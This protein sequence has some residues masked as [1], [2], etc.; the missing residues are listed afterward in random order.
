MYLN[1]VY[2]MKR[3]DHYAM[4]ILLLFKKL[5]QRLPFLR[6][7]R[8][9]IFFLNSTSPFLL[10]NKKKKKKDFH[11]Y[12]VIPSIVNARIGSAMWIP[13]SPIKRPTIIVN[14]FP[15]QSVKRW[16]AIGCNDQECF[17]FWSCIWVLEELLC[18]P[19]VWWKAFKLKWI[20]CWVLM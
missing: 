14:K 5:K 10:D 4:W 3:K 11:L 1:T 18:P 19:T 9:T 12:I 8:E 17:L 7:F 2:Y 6:F 15:R 16:I 13:C 20:K